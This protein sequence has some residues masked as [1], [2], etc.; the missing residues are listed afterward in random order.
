MVEPGLELQPEGAA[1]VLECSALV[2]ADLHLGCE[3]A[4]EYEGISIPRLQTRKL[5][6]SLVSM[7]ERLQPDSLVVAGDLKHNFSRNLTQEWDDVASFVRDITELVD[8]SVVRGNHD[9]YLAAIMSQS[10]IALSK[11]LRVGRFRVLHG[12]SGAPEGPTI[13]G[14]MHPSVGLSDSL[15]GRVK[16]PCFLHEPETHTLVLPAMSI[17]SPGL[18]VVG[19]PEADSLS[20]LVAAIGLGRF[21]P[22]VFDEDRPLVFPRLE[23]MRTMHARQT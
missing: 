7:V 3:A 18:D 8:V 16:R 15:G 17:V 20:P 6:R 21:R 12:H 9:N 1:L 10:G 14:H 5:R 4:L 22:I 13:M 19:N 2:V 23:K 11:E